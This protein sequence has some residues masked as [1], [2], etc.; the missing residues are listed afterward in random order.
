MLRLLGEGLSN[1]GVA[2]TLCVAVRTVES[3]VT[4]ILSKLDV[5]S[6]LEAVAWARHHVVDE[7]WGERAS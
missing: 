6:R 4:S 3:Q 1:R 7:S 2:R 5:A